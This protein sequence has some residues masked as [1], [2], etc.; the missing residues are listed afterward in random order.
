MEAVHYITSHCTRCPKLMPIFSHSFPFNTL[1]F[2][3]HFCKCI[4]QCLDH[5]CRKSERKCEI[6]CQWVQS[7]S[8][9]FLFDSSFLMS[10]PFSPISF[11]SV[12]KLLS[13]S[14]FSPSLSCLI[15][16]AWLTCKN[17]YDAYDLLTK[18]AWL[19]SYM[20]TMSMHGV[21]MAWAC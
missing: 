13:P 4:S 10:F 16:S 20:H 14:F 7:P 3:T 1:L 21:Q 8:L 2:T 6:M 17:M 19:P 9:S 15:C 18:Y 5:F 11:S 12:D